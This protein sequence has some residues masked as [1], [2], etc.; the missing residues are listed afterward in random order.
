MTGIKVCGG[1]GAA[2]KSRTS[3]TTSAGFSIGSPWLAPGTIASS[4]AGKASYIEHV[5]LGNV[6]EG[7]RHFIRLLQPTAATDPQQL[8]RDVY[9]IMQGWYDASR[10]TGT[11]L[12]ERHL[13]K[14]I[15]E[16]IEAIRKNNVRMELDTLLFWRALLVLDATAL[17]FKSQFDLLG[18]LRGFFLRER[19]SPME[20]MVAL[21]TDADIA[22]D[23]FELVRSV[24]AD[25]RQSVEDI[26]F[27]RTL[28]AIRP[29]DAPQR[30]RRENEGARQITAAV[31]VTAMLLLLTRASMNVIGEAI[32]WMGL[33][34]SAALLMRRATS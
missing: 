19:P 33:A 17:R 7:Y 27:D 29:D 11:S 8:R 15:G 25:A 6:P 16:F 28:I 30:A 31:I 9:A 22:Y 12:A 18:H 32:T 1:D 20:R 13:G 10:D 34:G 14:F 21:V 2:K 24:P 23:A 3:R 26:T 4:L 5:S